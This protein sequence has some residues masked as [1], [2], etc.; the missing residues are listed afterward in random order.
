[1][2]PTLGMGAWLAKKHDPPHIGY[3]VEFDRC[4]STGASISLDISQNLDPLR[5]AFQSHSR[6]VIGTDTD[7]SDTVSN[8]PVS[9]P[10]YMTFY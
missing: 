3:H 8:R 1:M 9:V 4:R 2:G 6:K 10:I 5:P 7:R